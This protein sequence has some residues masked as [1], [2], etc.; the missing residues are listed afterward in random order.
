MLEGKYPTPNKYPKMATKAPK[1]P[2]AAAKA[3]PVILGE[4]K[5][6][7]VK[8]SEEDKAADTENYILNPETK[9][10]VK[11][12]TPLGIRLSKGESVGKKMTD[13]QRLVLFVETI[14]KKH[15]LEDAVIK[16]DLKE[17]SEEF[18]RGFPMKWGGK[19]KAVR[20]KDH[21]KMH[22]NAYIFFTKAVRGDVAK[23]N[24]GISNTQVVSIMA[25]MWEE[26]KDREVYNK[27]AADDKIRYQKEMLARQL[28][29]RVA[30]NTK[31]ISPRVQHSCYYYPL[32]YVGRFFKWSCAM[33]Q[34][35]VVC[36]FCV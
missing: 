18:P 31:C 7:I 27:L 21:P 22:I 2:K 1:V 34:Q 32:A 25:K 26:T 6:S 5:T 11:R 24:P 12:T 4:T 10:H 23:K 33:L 28:K 19:Q 9:K 20:P 36:H 17:I 35:A 29:V 15:S 13:T 14:Q 3:S 8:L 30:D 16:D